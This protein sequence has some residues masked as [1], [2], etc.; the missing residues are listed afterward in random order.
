MILAKPCSCRAIIKGQLNIFGPV[1][2]ASFTTF[3]FSPLPL[4]FLLQ[5]LAP[6]NQ[7]SINAALTIHRTQAVIAMGKWRYGV[8]LDAG[9]S[10]TRVYIYRWLNA[11][12]AK[13]AADDTLLS[14]LPALQT[15]KK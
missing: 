12:K 14:T 5:S 7:N 3:A 15:K 4:L 1:A 6:P 9:S 8:I 13:A 2:T 10:G 11:A